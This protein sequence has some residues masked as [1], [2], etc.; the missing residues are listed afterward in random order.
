MSKSAGQA[1]TFVVILLLASISP[2]TFFGAAHPS[3]A[4]SVDKPHIILEDGYSDNLTLTIGNNGTS[5]ESYNI[6]LNLTGLSNVWNITSVNQT[7]DN[8]LPTFAKD[9][10]FVIRLDTG[11]TPS[12]SG[13]FEITVTEPDANVSS[14]I[15]VYV[16]V[17]PSYESSIS[18]SSA[19]GA[20]QQMTAGT[21][22]NY[23]LDVWND[24]NVEDTLLLDIDVEPDLAAFWTNWSSGGGNNTGGNNTG[25]NNTNTTVFIPSNLLMYGN[26]YVSSNNLDVLMNNML[27]VSG[28]NN[29]TQALTGGGMKLSQHWAEVNT[30]GDN[31]NTTLRNNGETWDYVILQD[32][33]QVPGFDRSEPLWI[34]SKDAAVNLSA[35]IEDEDSETILMMTWGRRNG[36]TLNPILYSNFTLMQD[37]LEDGYIDYHDNMSTSTRDVWIAPVG[38]AFKQIHDSIN[39]TGLDPTQPGNTFYDLYSADGSHPSLAGSYLAA[40]V[41][42]ATMTGDSPVGSNDTVSL[43]ASLKLELQNAAAVTVFNE[44]SHLSYPWQN[45][46][47]TTITSASQTSKVVPPGWNLFFDDNELTDIAADSYVQSI[48]QISVP[49]DAI[50]GFYGFNLFSASTRGNVS[51]YSTMVIEVIAENEISAVF[52]DQDANFIPGQSK[53]TSVQVTNLGNAVLDM[54]WNVEVLNGPCQISL[55]TT[56]SNNFAP[57]DIVYV[58]IQVIVDANSSSSD[59]CVTSLGGSA[60]FGEQEFIPPVFNFTIGIDEKVEFE[61]LIPEGGIEVVPGNPISYQLRLNNTGS[62]EVEFFLD[63]GNSPGLTTI[64]STSSGVIIGPGAVGIW[65]LSTDADGEMVGMYSQTF[66]T[67]YGG[68]TDEITLV[69]DVLEV[70]ALSLSGPI[71]GRISTMP[72]QTVYIDLEL[73]NMGTKDISSTAA[74]S[75]LPTGAQVSFDPTSTSLLV[76][77]SIMINMTVTMVSTVDS[78][79]HSIIVTYNSEDTSASLNLELQ[80]ADSIGVAVS[81]VSNN[82][83]AGPLTNVNY[84]FEITNLGSAQDTFFITLSYDDSNNATTWFDIVLSTTSISLSP[85]STQVASISVRESAVGALQSG[86]PVNVHVSSSNDNLV[87]DINTFSII[88]IKVSAEITILEDDDSAKPGDSISGT[89]VVTNTGTGIDQFL[90]TTPGNSCGLSEIF[91]LNPGASSQAYPWS[92][93]ISNESASGIGSLIFRVTSGARTNFVLEDIE[94]YTVEPTWDSSGILELNFNNEVLTMSSSGGSITTFTVKNLANAPITGTLFLLGSDGSLFDSSLRPIGSNSTSNEFNLGNGE[95]VI[96]ELILNSRITESESATLSFS[97]NIELDGNSYSQESSILEVIIEGPELPPS[98]VDLLFGIQLDKNQ[99]LSTMIG[100]WGFSILLLLLMNTLRKRR[101]EVSAHSDAKV[102]EK[103]SAKEKKKKE[104]EVEAHDLALNECRMTIDHKVNCP[105]CDAKLGVP[106][107][108]IPPFKFTCPKCDT[109]IRVLESLKF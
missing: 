33:S 64:L 91:I 7:V 85:S 76:G 86:V 78:G 61:L 31:W 80:I 103:K 44:T 11:A 62:E 6:T 50:P 41:L 32:Q 99:T 42:Y 39:L 108:S 4:L 37:R 25:G 92:C 43:S 1:I 96:F 95:Y 71:D 81:S 77:E 98:G 68:A 102:E 38:L 56:S 8:V 100:G 74:V 65:S 94:Y 36:D 17:A 14:S 21:S 19:N 83:A 29:N 59:E 88:P 93:A 45:S 47:T 69:V 101:K 70:P 55:M 90:L 60:S 40:C 89:V 18:F 105:S 72:G 12:D 15:T 51:S 35:A 27:N 5:I 104:E 20:Y 82:I 16:S 9:T 46:S 97:V 26:S 58:D 75:G 49:S 106:R 22:M 67:S 53:Q 52:L 24:G 2:M 10:T 73:T 23:T 13:S 57:D 28:E 30:P 87:S 48:L 54:D 63:I 84:S 3:I 66:S 34:A 107:G 109:K 79:V